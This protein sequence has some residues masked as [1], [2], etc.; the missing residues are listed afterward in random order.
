MTTHCWQNTC[1][2]EIEWGVLEATSQEY[3]SRQTSQV[4]EGVTISIAI[5]VA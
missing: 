4:D 3:L 1:P 5:V 2:H